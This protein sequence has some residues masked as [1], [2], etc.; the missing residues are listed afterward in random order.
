M[1]NY[2]TNESAQ[3]IDNKI[4]DRILKLHKL[5]EQGIGGE[6]ENAQK[7]LDKLLK[8]HGLTLSE[9]ND[10]EEWFTINFKNR[11]EKRLIIQIISKVTN[12]KTIRAYAEKNQ[13]NLKVNKADFAEILVMFSVYRKA[14]EKEFQNIYIAFVCKQNIFSDCKSDD[15]STNVED[16]IDIS[17]LL[18]LTELIDRVDVH[19][20]IEK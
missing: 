6:K 2:N 13:I 18:N 10:C 7:I 4:R 3:D 19:K 1:T 11:F 12:I 16:M 9:I 17:K 5:V 8:K 20:L 15:D 14:L